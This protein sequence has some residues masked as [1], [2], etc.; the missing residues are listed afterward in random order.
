MIFM[1]VGAVIL[2]IAL[3]WAGLFS[4]APTQQFVTAEARMADLEDTVLAT[5][6]LEPFEMVSVGA[7]VSGQVVKLHVEVGDRVKIGTPIAEIDSLPQQNALRNAQAALDNVKAQRLSMQAE[8]A[9]AELNFARQQK[10]LNADATSRED[11]EAARATLAT[12]KASIAALDAQIRQADITA[13]TARINLGYTRIN[14]PIDGIVVA[15]VTEEGRTVNANQ[16]APTIVMIAKLDT[17]TVEAQ[18]SEADVM[19]VKPDQKV[20]FT[21]LGAP[22]KRYYAK[23]R[24][25]DPAPTSIAN[26]ASATGSSSSSTTEEAIYYNGLFDVPNPNGELR[27]M[28][29]AQVYIVLNEAKNV[30]LIPA[31]ALGEKGKD[32]SYSVR[33]VNEQGEAIPR[34]VKI[35]LNNKVDAQV[36]SGLKAGDK[37]VIGDS[38]GAKSMQGFP[39]GPRMR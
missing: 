12:R 28:M 34:K 14:A 6:Q 7:Q 15:V 17:M 3:W 37:V 16:S 4:S 20:Y 26:T 5:G 10:M 32:G 1:A 25:I 21:V 11:Y 22:D 36:L 27:A 13:D 31:T 39:G 23:L 2:A 19:R 29:T 38:A 8:L 35:G 18:I 33:V 9:Q 24:S 30:L